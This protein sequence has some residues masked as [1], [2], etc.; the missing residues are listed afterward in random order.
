MQIGPMII[1]TASASKLDT[2]ELVIPEIQRLLDTHKVNELVAHQL[3]HHRENG[4]AW[5]YPPI[6]LARTSETG[7]TRFVVDGQHRLAAMRDLYSAHSHDMEFAMLTYSVPTLKRLE[8][9]Y[10][11]INKNAPIP[12]FSPFSPDARAPA[13]SV[14]VRL[15]TRFPDIW[16]ASARA[17]RP[18]LNFTLVQQSLAWLSQK[19]GSL[20]AAALEAAVLELNNELEG[21]VTLAARGSPETLPGQPTARMVAKA[22]KTGMYLGLYKDEP[23][24]EYGYRWTAVLAER[25]TGTAVLRRRK[26]R[27]KGVP[28]SV[29]LAAWNRY[30]GASVARTKCICCQ[31]REISMAVF[32]AGHVVAEA[33]GGSATVANV[34]PICGLCNKSMATR[35]MAA[36]VKEHYPGNLSRFERRDYH[37]SAPVKSGWL[38]ALT[39]RS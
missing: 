37:E 20:T 36:F 12:D 31:E 5:P 28:K 29:K 38:S 2:M 24:S 26:A 4:A 11:E 7:G 17:R 6:V 33:E 8:C 34:L 13:E 25:L 10:R 1:S 16:S 9:L 21:R 15:K 19:T 14:A 22:V 23:G 3:M 27:R 39:G 35:P 18:S 32:E 30:V